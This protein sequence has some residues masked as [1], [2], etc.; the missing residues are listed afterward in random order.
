MQYA[1]IKDGSATIVARELIRQ[2]EQD[3]KNGED[4][5]KIELNYRKAHSIVAEL[6]NIS[7]VRDLDSQITPESKTAMRLEKQLLA[8]DPQKGG[9]E[10]VMILLNL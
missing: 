1:S 2:I 6:L 7:G 4:E 5:E 10:N 9:D 8:L 3:I